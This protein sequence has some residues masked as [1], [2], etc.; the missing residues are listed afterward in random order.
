MVYINDP[1]NSTLDILN[2]VNSFSSVARYKINS[3]KSIAFLY[4]KNKHAEKEI[5]EQHPS[6]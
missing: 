6:Q 2:L 4:T 5:M 1:K 3:N